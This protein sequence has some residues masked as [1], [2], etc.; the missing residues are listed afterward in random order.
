MKNKACM[1][2]PVGT[3]SLSQNHPKFGSY[4]LAGGL[5]LYFFKSW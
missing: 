1:L 3:S 4:G 5:A 2:L